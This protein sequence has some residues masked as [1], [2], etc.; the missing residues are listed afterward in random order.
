MKICKY[1]PIFSLLLIISCNDKPSSSSQTVKPDST[2][3]IVNKYVDTLT[4]AQDKAKKVAGDTNLRV[5]Q[6]NQ[7]AQEMDKQ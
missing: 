6:E 7:A 3:E 4:T 2:G 1:L 5:D